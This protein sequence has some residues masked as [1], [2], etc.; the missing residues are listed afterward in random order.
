MEPGVLILFL[1]ALIVIFVIVLYLVYTHDVKVRRQMWEELADTYGMGFNSKDPFDIPDTYPFALFQK[2]HSRRAYNCLHGIYESL[3]VILFDY[4]YAIGWGRQTDHYVTA[5]LGRL[6]I[7]CPKLVIRPVTVLDRF[8]GLVG[9]GEI[10]FESEEFNR[11]FNVE[12]EDK[13]FA[14]DICHPEMMELLLQKPSLTWELQGHSLLVYSSSIGR[15]DAEE[16]GVCLDLALGFVA[17]IPAYLKKEE[18]A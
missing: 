3:P 17:R 6:N 18:H 2:G 11:I 9:L 1:P 16:V 8:A 12:G 4:Y 14:Y 10:H 13:K 7:Y 5:L 15:F